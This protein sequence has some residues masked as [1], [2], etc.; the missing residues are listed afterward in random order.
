MLQL[1][2]PNKVEKIPGHL[3]GS[4]FSPGCVSPS[5]PSA[6][7]IFYPHHN[8][9]E[10]VFPTELENKTYFKSKVIRLGTYINKETETKEV[11]NGYEFLILRVE[12]SPLS[13]FDPAETTLSFMVIIV[14]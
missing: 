13:N 8:R 2:L 7:H 6:W 9:N 14:K 12:I 4:S 3:E 10:G 1:N 5:S 11:V